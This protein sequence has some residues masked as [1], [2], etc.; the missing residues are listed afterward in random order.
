MVRNLFRMLLVLWAG[1]LW[2]LAAWVAPTLFQL[3]ADR[4]Q[5][6][7]LAA[8]LFSIEAYL[9]MAVAAAALLLE[10]TAGTGVARMGATRMGATRMGGTGMGATRMGG[11]YV[12]A[13]LLAVSEFVLKR[14]M[15][16]ARI[17]GAAG[18]LTFGA[19]H[20]ISAMLYI[21]A[22]LAVLVAIWKEDFR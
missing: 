7:V 21:A 16:A 17:E 3:L 4:H 8:R 2:S 22:C 12:A 14:F 10:R 6:G 5:A 18:G 9:G 13:A 1:S 19:W 20:G 11:L 15:E